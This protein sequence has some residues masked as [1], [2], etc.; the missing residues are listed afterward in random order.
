MGNLL[1]YLFVLVLFWIFVFLLQQTSF[2]F[3]DTARLE[4]IAAEAIRHSYIR[5]LP[6]DLATAC[7]LTLPVALGGLTL[8]FKEFRGP[9]NGIR[10]F[11]VAM[12]VNSFF[13]HVVDIGLFG[14]WGTK[15]N[16]KALSYLVYPE[17]AMHGATGAPIAQLIIILLAEVAIALLV[18]FRIDHQRSFRTERPWAKWTAPILVPALL[19]IGMR[20]GLQ[21]FPIDRSWSYHSSHPILNLGA[22]NGTWNVIVLLAEPPEISANP[23]AF[24]T[25]EEADQRFMALHAKCD[26]SRKRS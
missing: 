17:E 9:R 19:L 10:I 16:H 25:K 24:M 18:V 7:Y 15:V 2:L 3:F 20:G 5:A 26:G 6:M 21:P 13:V 11:L 12:V 23:H 22:L 14:A 1:R 4:G 8:L